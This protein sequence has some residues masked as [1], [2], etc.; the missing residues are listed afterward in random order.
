MFLPEDEQVPYFPYIQE[1]SSGNGG[2]R[3]RRVMTLELR[4]GPNCCNRLQMWEEIPT[5]TLP[6]SDNVRALKKD[7]FLIL[8][9]IVACTERVVDNVSPMQ[10]ET[11]WKPLQMKEPHELFTSWGSRIAPDMTC[12]LLQ[13]DLKAEE[14]K[15]LYLLSNLSME[16]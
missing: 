10:K 8:N 1:E 13:G 4:G 15:G 12:E 6:N 16:I 9:L 5:Q 7:V 14:K 2:C 11:R 3:L